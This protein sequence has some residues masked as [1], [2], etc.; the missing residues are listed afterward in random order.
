MELPCGAVMVR[1]KIVFLKASEGDVKERTD[2]VEKCERLA[3]HFERD[4][5][6]EGDCDELP[7]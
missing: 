2:W 7:F 3:S 6:L 4:V 5:G 1:H